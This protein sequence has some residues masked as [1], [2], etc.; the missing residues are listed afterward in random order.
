MTVHYQA[1]G[2]AFAVS[3][4]RTGDTITASLRDHPVM[5][6]VLQG[7]SL[8]MT[9]NYQGPERERI[10]LH[11]FEYVL[12]H[13]TDIQLLDCSALEAPLSDTLSHSLFMHKDGRPLLDRQAFFQYAPLWHRRQESEFQP[14]RWTSTN[15]RAHPARPFVEPG[16]LYSRYLP[17]VGKTLGF[18]LFDR[19]KHLDVF[20]EW[21]NQH[22]VSIFWEMPHSR[23]KLEEY[24]IKME[25]DPHQRPVIAL[26]DGQPVGYYEIYWTPEDR[27][28]PYYEYDPFDRGFHFLIGEISVLG[29]QATQEFI[30]SMVHFILLDDPRTRRVMGEPR[31]DNVKLL[32]Y[33]ISIPSWTKVKEFDFPHKRAALLQCRREDFFQSGSL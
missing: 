16:L 13:H 22:R 7:D 1:P 5:S 12:G 23:E 33:L 10:H 18:E 21:H 24:I 6:F 31:H 19:D 11:V 30:Q 3:I 28:G 25:A 4:S 2:A 26:L 29:G 32:R 9:R 8:S 27:L 15:E 14:E 20:H 17:S